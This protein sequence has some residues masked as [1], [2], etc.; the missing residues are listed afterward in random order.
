ML[1]YD[2]DEFSTFRPKTSNCQNVMHPT[3]QP[4]LHVRFALLADPA[5]RLH[6]DE[7]ETARRALMVNLNG[8]SNELLYKPHRD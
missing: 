5:V 6:A 4:K 8:M 2:I 3:I 7:S 1:R